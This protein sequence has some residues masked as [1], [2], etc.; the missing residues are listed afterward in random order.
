MKRFALVF[1]AAV[2]VI[3]SAGCVWPNIA[4]QMP[5]NGGW[6][7]DDYSLSSPWF[8]MHAAKIKAVENQLTNVAPV[9]LL[10]KKAGAAGVYEEVKP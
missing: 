9:L 8:T 3:L 5:T 6:E 1:A 2:A 7:V 4:K 10:K